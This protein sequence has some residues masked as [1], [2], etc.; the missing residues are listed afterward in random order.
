MST[1]Q[2]AS[3]NVYNGEFTLTVYC[4]NP[5]RLACC[6]E[7]HSVKQTNALKHQSPLENT[8]VIGLFL[9]KTNKKQTN[10]FVVKRNTRE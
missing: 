1:E 9:K 10:T 5:L 4:L 7:M 2:S 8:S 6:Y 3:G